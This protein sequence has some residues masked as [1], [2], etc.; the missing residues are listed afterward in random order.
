MR[1]GLANH[2]SYS[3]ANKVRKSNNHILDKGILYDS[4]SYKVDKT[5]EIGK[6]VNTNETMY[7]GLT[8]NNINHLDSLRIQ[9]VLLSDICSCG[10]DKSYHLNISKCL[11]SNCKC[12][13]FL[14]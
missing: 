13:R 10:H 8:G 5:V 1:Q 6:S 9:A 7:S 12:K 4:P 14:P 11:E 3:Q 2:I